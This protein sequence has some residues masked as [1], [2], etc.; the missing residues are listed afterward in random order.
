MVSLKMPT[1]LQSYISRT[2][3]QVVD[4]YPGAW[5]V[6]CDPRGDWL[7]LLEKAAQGQAENGFT[8]LRVE[9]ETAGEMGGPLARAEVQTRLD[10]RESFVLYV[11]ADAKK[12]GWL[13]AQALLAERIYAVS[14]RE[15]LR[16]WG[17]R[18]ASLTINDA[19]IAA[20]ARQNIGQDPARWGGGGLEPK[21]PLLLELLAN[22]VIP[23]DDY[24]LV[25]DL[26]IERAGL[27]P[28]DQTSL[29]SAS[30]DS[31]SLNKTS[32]D[33]WRRKALARWLVTQAESIAPG[34]AQASPEL[35]IRS[36][37]QRKLAFEVLESWM[38]SNRLREKLFD[39]VVKADTLTGL[40]N[41]P[42]SNLTLA[43]APR[44]FVSQAAE[45][46]TFAAICRNLSE[47]T[48]RKL[49]EAL[50]EAQP[51]LV[52]HNRGLWGKNCAASQALPWGEL[53]R[54]AKAAE[55]M[56]K[57]EPPTAHWANPEEACRW[58]TSKGWQMDQAGEEFLKTLEK[59][60]PEL[61]DL[62][63]PL[64][65]AYLAR[66]DATM[67]QWSEVWTQARC[68][69]P[70]LGTAG[71][72]MKRL[73]DEPNRPTAIIVS[74]AMRYDIAHLIAGRVNRQEGV[75]RAA[76]QPARTALPTITALGMGLALPV[77]EKELEAE[78][79][80][81]KWVLRHKDNPA[82]NLSLAA[83][84]REWWKHKGKVNPDYLLD[85]GDLLNGN[86]PAPKK[87]AARL[88]AFDA[89]IDTLGHE[90][91]LEGLGSGLVVE[92]YSAAIQRLRDKGWHRI[93]VVTDHG[94][95]H[96]SGSADEKH[97][98]PPAPEPGYTSRRAIA[99]P[100]TVQLEGPQGF[101]PGGKWKVAFTYGTS[102]FR[103]YGGLGFFH[104]GASLQ[105]WIVPCIQ[106]EWPK[107][108]EPIS[109]ELL[110]L[111]Q[112][113]SLRVRAVLRVIKENSLLPEDALPREIEVLIRP[114]QGSGILFRSDRITIRP[115][116][117]EV[118][119]NLKQVTNAQAERGIPLIIQA[120]D[121]ATE[122]IIH[123]IKSV[124]RV[125]LDGW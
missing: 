97:V 7:P 102:T 83:D 114:A 73:L 21:P 120:R 1:S 46:A 82:L 94:F 27:P 99:Y 89:I 8:L 45:S 48:G 91:E 22:G 75:D 106:V 71:E 105:E 68:A 31:A 42:V 79:V 60:T 86:L 117:S 118:S 17:W 43:A 55:A 51:Q 109:V 77:F 65:N 100:A 33:Q 87:G 112:V 93:L 59:P 108:A 36:E 10:H 20:M 52:H 2:V 24:R 41:P 123:E 111:E 25:L 30:L 18:P 116:E 23:D 78:I 84:R 70:R 63:T 13:W 67:Q 80:G 4:S 81:G 38:D 58:Y 47:K 19:E 40:R 61:L 103:S 56:L 66:W 50:A 110:P 26:T 5:L 88:V 115:D 69:V 72:W 122:E 44:P 14:L 101:A 107:K 32:L 64:R 95:I 39:L 125:A 57:A 29:E 124:L 15:Q 37:E 96:W 98:D 74:D 16:E 92:R 54:L 121:A 11:K 49:L 6:W 90:E 76:V 104:G 34:A 35:L 85:L 9:G 119:V 12:L 28:L 113:L 62:I 53:E 3:R